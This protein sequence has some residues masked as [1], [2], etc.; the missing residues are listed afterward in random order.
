MSN[1][2]DQALIDDLQLLSQQLNRQAF[3]QPPVEGWLNSFLAL[4]CERFATEGVT[5]AQV[6]QV[7][8]NIMLQVANAG[9]VPT[10]NGQQNL[11]DESSPLMPALRNLEIAT[12]PN[13]Q[14]YPISAGSES[15]GVLIINYDSTR[16]NV[17][18]LNRIFST[19]SPQMGPALLQH[20]KTPGPRTG[21]LMRQIDMMRNFY[22]VT[23]SFSAELDRSDLLSKAAKTIVETLQIDHVGIVVYDIGQ[24]VGTVTAEFPN[25]GIVGSRV[26]MATTLQNRLLTTRQPIIIN[27]VDTEP[28]IDAERAIFQQLGIKSIAILPMLVQDDLIGSVGLDSFYEYH[29]FTNEEIDAATAIT[30]QLAISA[31]NAHLY[32]QLRRRAFQFERIAELSRRITSTFDRTRIF[33]IAREETQRLIEADQV[34]V[35]LRAQDTLGLSLNVLAEGGIIIQDFALE[36]SGLRFVFNS[37][38]PLVL[39]D[40]SRSEEPDYRYMYNLQMR[41]AAIVPLMAG[42]Q[43]GG[44]YCVLHHLPGHYLSLDL[45]LLEQISN[46]VAIALENAR[47][48][49]QTSQRAETERLM[50]HL[51]DKLQVRGDL[52]GMLL[53]T[54]KEIA[55]ALGAKR[56]RVRLEVPQNK[57]PRRS[58]R[59]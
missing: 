19:I 17:A 5:G 34:V 40:I 36:R 21:R 35:A 50:N 33:Q 57:M 42:G 1:P 29:T 14:I 8:G 56:G 49:T 58:D 59:A 52:H 55:D 6:V 53:N 47:L 24:R 38:E 30:S 11:L 41:A 48:H 28:E 16:A 51:T 54:V 27:N 10:E 13:G 20:L 37:A 4:I 45:A 43:V 31:H 18:T 39:D 15:L 3:A 22:E 25:S 26:Q 44:A 9:N 2:A 46:Q 32:E 7:I 23:R 12:M